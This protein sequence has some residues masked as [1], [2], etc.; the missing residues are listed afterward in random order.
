MEFKTKVNDSMEFELTEEAA[1]NLNVA[2]ISPNKL[3]IIHDH[4]SYRAHI[5]K[6]DFF[7]KTYTILIHNTTYTVEIKHELDAL[8]SQMGF[9]IGSK[10]HVGKIYA[11]MPGLILEIVA[12][13]GQLVKEGDTLLILEAMKMENSITAPFEGII[14]SINAIK[15]DS[16]EK[17]QLLIEFE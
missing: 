1:I 5:L 3:H 4:K 14:K 15:G 17:N 9:N 10:L 2:Y 12:Q 11:P 16:V 7:S 6:T 8:I 13:S